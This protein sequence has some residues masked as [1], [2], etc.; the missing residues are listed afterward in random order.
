MKSEQPG[1][2]WPALLLPSPKK[3]SNMSTAIAIPEQQTTTA[4]QPTVTPHEVVRGLVLKTL[5]DYLRL[6]NVL[7]K[8]GYFSDMREAAQAVVKVM[9]GAELGFGPLA[10]MNGIHIVSGKPTL[11]AALIGAAI[12]RSGKYNYRIRSHDEFAC[13]LEFFEG[14][15]SIGHSTFT[16]EDATRAKLTTGRNAHTWLAYPR[17]ML[18]ARAISNGARWFTPDVFGGPV[19]TPEELGME[20]NEE[21]EA[22]NIE[23]TPVAPAPVEPEPA[24]V[25][26]P[27]VSVKEELPEPE[28]PR[29]VQATPE[30]MADLKK[31]VLALR[32]YGVADDEIKEFFKETTGT[33]T[34]RSM[35]AST[36]LTAKAITALDKWVAE[37]DQRAAGEVDPEN[38]NNPFNT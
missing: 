28:K 30:Q 38:E 24:P 33:K 7:I 1:K 11:S 25:E 34:Q 12:K 31:L 32:D 5:D 20:V 13:D 27:F 18:F 16:R 2:E 19:Y 3:E 14:K 10:S 17:N 8:S 21:G 37:C 26:E 23:S 29:L 35:T 15:E 22:I 6:G 9:A 36:E 4:L